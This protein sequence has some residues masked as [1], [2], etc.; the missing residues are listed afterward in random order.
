[1]AK[2]NDSNSG[3]VSF[4]ALVLAVSVLMAIP[5]GAWIAI[6]VVVGVI[7]VIAIVAAA[8]G[9]HNERKEAL[10]AAAEAERRAQAITDEKARVARLG[11]GNAKRVDSAI[12]AAEQVAASEA[13]REG[14][15]GEVDFSIDIAEI[16]EGFERAVALRSVADEL[17]RLDSPTAEDRRIL[18]EAK[19]TVSRLE[20]AAKKRVDLIARC[21]V[22]ARLIDE[23]LRK[24]RADARTAEQRVQLHGELAAMLYGLEAAPLT[25]A[26]DS[27]ADRVMARVAGYRE[28]T[29]QIRLARAEGLQ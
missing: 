27:G 9:S 28:V 10:V 15:L 4:V 8:V 14:W 21:A 12:K 22:E 16:S 19:T 23:S 2:G 1:M 3:C 7:A 11:K 5:T 18:S 13:A 25:P 17:K 29:A 24:E 20:D 6:G 26:G